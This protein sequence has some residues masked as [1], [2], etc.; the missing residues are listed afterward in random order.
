MIKY[1]FYYRV[2]DRDTS[3]VIDNYGNPDHTYLT[4]ENE[5]D[6]IIITLDYDQIDKLIDKLRTLRDNLFPLK[7]DKGI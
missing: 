6:D 7:L 3:L 5:Y 2:R 1:T 4:M